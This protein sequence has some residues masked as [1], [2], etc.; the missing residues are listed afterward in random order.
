MQRRGKDRREDKEVRVVIYADLSW[1]RVTMQEA[2]GMV[3]KAKKSKK[4]K[5]RRYPYE[6]APDE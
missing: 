6:N 3:R 2:C 4:A 5:Q 1:E